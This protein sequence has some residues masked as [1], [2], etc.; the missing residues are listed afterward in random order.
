[1]VVSRI[2]KKQKRVGG[3]NIPSA[4][5]WNLDET[6]ERSFSLTVGGDEKRLSEFLSKEP[7]QIWVGHLIIKDGAMPCVKITGVSNCV[8][9]GVA[10]LCLG[11]G[12]VEDR[13][14]RTCWYEACRMPSQYDRTAGSYFLRISGEK[15]REEAS[16]VVMADALYSGGLAWLD[17]MR[18]LSYC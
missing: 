8:D 3:I 10:L 5:E 15:E 13:V 17:A 12:E 6:F 18:M 16:A 1:M 4:W 7:R 11:K 14:Y 9:Y 2:G